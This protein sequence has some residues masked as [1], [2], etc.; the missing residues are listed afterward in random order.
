M[1][2]DYTSM[3][4]RLVNIHRRGLTSLE[5]FLKSTH[6]PLLQLMQSTVTFAVRCK[7]FHCCL[8]LCELFL[9]P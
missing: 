2:L 9:F 8:G 5:T 1:M 7:T 6:T 3:R 4:E